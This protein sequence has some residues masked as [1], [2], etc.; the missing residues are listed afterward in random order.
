GRKPA[1]LRLAVNAIPKLGRDLDRRHTHDSSIPKSIRLRLPDF[2]ISSPATSVPHPWFSDLP[3]EEQAD[4][5]GGPERQGATIGAWQSRWI[6]SNIGE[7]MVRSSDG[8]CPRAKASRRST[9]SGA[10]TWM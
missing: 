2:R 5:Q 3:V 6:G 9:F 7:T 4:Q 8:L 10:R 1:L